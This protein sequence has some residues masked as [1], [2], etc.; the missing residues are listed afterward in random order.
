MRR[1]FLCI[2]IGLLTFE[3]GVYTCSKLNHLAD[4][5]GAGISAIPPQLTDP[6]TEKSCDRIT[7]AWHAG[8]LS[9]NIP[10]SV[11]V[12]CWGVDEGKRHPI[13]QIIAHCPGH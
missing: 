3:I 11:Q 5:F 1:L 13:A 2:A 12:R 9:R 7:T 8:T 6:V 10:S 4:Y